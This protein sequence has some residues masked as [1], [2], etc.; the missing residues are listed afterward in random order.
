MPGMH[1]AAE[2]LQAAFERKE[3][4][5]IYGDYDVDGTIAIVILKTAIEL[6]GGTCE[7]HVPHRVRE[8]YGMKDDVIERAAADGVRLII[9]VDTGIRAFAAAETARRLGLDLIVTDHHLPQA[10]GVPHA[11]AVLNPNQPGCGYPCKSLC[12]AGVAFKLAQVIME[13][14]GLTRMLPSFLKVLAIATIADAVPLAGENRVFARLGLEALRNP[15]NVGLKALMD[16]AQ[17]NGGRALSA[18]EVAFRLAP[19]LNAAG[20]MDVA[21]DV[22]SLFSTRDAAQAREI[23]DRLNQLNVERQQEEQRIVQEIEERISGDVALRDAWC[24][25]ADGEGWHK[26]VIGIA[27]SRVLERYCRPVLVISR[28]GEQAQGSARSIEAFHMLDALESCAPLFTRFGG[29]AHAAG[30]ALPSERIPELRAALDARAH[31]SLRPEDLEPALRYDGELTLNQITPELYAELRRMEPFGMANPEPVFVARQLRLVAPPR[32]IKEKH[33]KLRVRQ[34]YTTQAITRVFDAMGWRMAERA[35][36]CPVDGL[37]DMAYRIVENTHPDY[38][39][40]ELNVCDF[41]RY[42]GEFR[43]QRASSSGA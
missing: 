34:S 39:G 17:V 29:H 40:L 7:F 28:E 6:C 12:G 41:A 36:D 43:V 11:V 18:G 1:A 5:L 31:Q 3:K 15:V 25:V 8:G 27:A 38:G 42:D 22:I 23:A 14:A 33:L 2:R 10:E 35:D 26:G 13:K 30:F 16:V 20:R 37:L 24:I 19:R 9:S 32:V 4:I 21:R